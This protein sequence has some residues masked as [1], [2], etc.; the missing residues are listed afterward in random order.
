MH[1]LDAGRSFVDLIVVV[2]SLASLAG[3]GMMLLTGSTP[4]DQR[5]AEAILSL[6]TVGAAWLLIPTSFAMRYARHWFNAQ[7]DSVDL[8]QDEPPSYSDFVYLAFTVAM[9]YAISDTDLK[10]SEIRRIAI[11]QAGLS[12][13][14]GTVIIAASINLLAGLAG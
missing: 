2:A 6:A 8:H 7:P 12:Y 3:V 14:F 4:A 10:T 9:T 13:L 5:F 11:R 1:G